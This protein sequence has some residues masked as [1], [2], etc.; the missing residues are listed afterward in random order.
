MDGESHADFALVRPKWPDMRIQHLVHETDDFIVAIDPELDLDWETTD[1]YDA[2]GPKEPM[3]HNEILN[4]AASLECIPNDHQKRSVRINFKRMIGEGIARSLKHDYDNAQ[5]ILDDALSYIK[6]RNVESARS[7]QIMTGFVAA[8][9]LGIATLTMWTLRVELRL[10]WGHTAFLFVFAALPGG[11]GAVLSMLFRIGHSF[12][13]S[14]APCRLHVLEAISRVLAG[15][16][17]GVAVA[18][19][20]KAGVVLSVLRD[21]PGTSA[22]IIS[23]LAAGVSERWVP[24][25]L[26]HLHKS[27]IEGLKGRDDTQ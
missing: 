17:S 13:S 23:S 24:S 6:V 10:L 22:L 16:L 4:L 21:T 9:V 25:L 20:I 2:T 1:E 14:E 26:V 12:P 18:V 11:L 5:R 15:C 19:A 7:W 8:A 3:R 27:S